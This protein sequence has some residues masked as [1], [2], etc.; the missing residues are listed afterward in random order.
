[1]EEY[2]GQI[3]SIIGAITIAIC[4]YNIFSLLDNEYLHCF[5][6]IG[7]G[8]LCALLYKI[9]VV[10]KLVKL[11]AGSTVSYLFGIPVFRLIS[12]LIIPEKYRLLSVM[13]AFFVTALVYTYFLCEESEG[14]WFETPDY[15]YFGGTNRV[16]DRLKINVK[17]F[18]SKSGKK[19]EKEYVVNH[20]HYTAPV[21]QEFLNENIRLRKLNV[22]Y[23]EQ[24]S[25]MKEQVDYKSNVCNDLLETV[26][27]LK[28][29]YE[30]LRNEHEQLKAKRNDSSSM[31]NT[32]NDNMFDIIFTGVSEEER[33][34][35]FRKLSLIFHPDS[36]TGDAEIFKMIKRAYDHS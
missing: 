2:K 29:E 9:A 27:N 3:L 12:S 10:G 22:S 6:A 16:I 34:K 19:K 31:N 8:F 30:A 1:M 4:F 7:I 18:I 13:I 33:K 15:C 25:R 11:L 35:R 21:S 32:S 26:E 24:L 36:D 23:Q 5:I 28:R 17:G 20:V 14:T